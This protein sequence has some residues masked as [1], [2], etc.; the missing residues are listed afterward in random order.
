MATV[1]VRVIPRAGKT[2]VTLEERGVVVRVRAAPERGRATE[3]AR[4]A[5]AAAVGVPVA[6]VTLR[7]GATARTK[8]FEID[9]LGPAEVALRL[10]ATRRR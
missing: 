6:A 10:R 3:E 9:G 1:T 4:K 8:M 5:L 7:T 2:A